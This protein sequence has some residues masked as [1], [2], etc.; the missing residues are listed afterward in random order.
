M[1]ISIKIE[2]NTP[3]ELREAVLAVAAAFGGA[4][5]LA[6]RLVGVN[7]DPAEPGAA[8]LVVRKPRVSPPEPDSNPHTEPDR[9]AQ[10]DAAPTT[11]R[12]EPEPEPE[13]KVAA[14]VKKELTPAEM[15]TQ[16]SDMLMQL[17]NRDPS[18]L[19]DLKK[20]QTK[21]GV[22]K[23]GDIPD[24]KAQAF[25]ADAMLIANGTGEVAA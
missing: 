4:G 21:Y 20:I 18:K 14:N 25:Y 16:G 7:A 15:R 24:D 3:D 13:Q 23:F 2:G 8:T 1:T 5:A 17:F 12:T 19:P 11:A 10:H 9:E 6:D 22:K